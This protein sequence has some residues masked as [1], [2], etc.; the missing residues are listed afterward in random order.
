M[1]VGRIEYFHLGPMSFKEFIDAIDPGM[2]KYISDFTLETGI[3]LSAYK[4]LLK[5]Q[6]E[7]LLVGGMPKAVATYRQNGAVSDV[8]DVHRSIVDTCLDDFS[9]YAVRFDLNMSNLQNVQH[10]ASTEKGSTSVTFNLLSLPLY[11]G[12]RA[13]SDCQSFRWPSSGY[14]GGKTPQKWTW[15]Q[16]GTIGS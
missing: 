9:K 10:T 14:G 2:V 6:R 12:R 7:Y 16:F 4:K 3:P 8:N 5:R 11:Y 13:A 15:K 1:P